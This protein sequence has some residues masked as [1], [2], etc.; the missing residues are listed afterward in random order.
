MQGG[1]KPTNPLARLVS[2]TGGKEDQR[3]EP[4]CYNS[5]CFFVS[6]S[7]LLEAEIANA[8]PS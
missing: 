8:K 6:Q 5:P 7:C 4:G 1:E 3:G 2:V